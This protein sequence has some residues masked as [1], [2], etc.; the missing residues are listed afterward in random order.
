M[1]N[2]IKVLSGVREQKFQIRD[3]QAVFYLFSS[4]MSTSLS[5]E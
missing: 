3:V 2:D 1:E 5:F 4:L